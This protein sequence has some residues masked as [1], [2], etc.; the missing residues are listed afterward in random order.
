MLDA[1]LDRRTGRADAGR[2]AGGVTF[3]EFSGQLSRE[4]LRPDHRRSRRPALRRRARRLDRLLGVPQLPPVGG[5]PAARLPLPAERRRPR[6]AAIMDVYLLSPFEWQRP[7]PAT[8]QWLGP[9]ESWIDAEVLGS[10]GRILDQ[11]SFNIPTACRSGSALPRPRPTPQPVP[12]EQ[13]PALPL[14]P[15]PL[16]R[17]RGPA[18]PAD[19]RAPQWTEQTDSA[20]RCGCDDQRITG[21]EQLVVPPPAREGGPDA[22]E[23]LCGSR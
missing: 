7:P 2:D 17:D 12:G 3:R 22:R 20:E 10:T 9:E 16:A 6:V 11:D 21:P 23:G 1:M 8:V 5:L 18:P 13:G 14:R 15:R 19:Q 4:S